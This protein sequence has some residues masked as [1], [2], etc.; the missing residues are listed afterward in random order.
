MS[1]TQ[2]SKSDLF[3]TFLKLGLTSFGGPIAHLGYFRE[4]F[5]SRLKWMD[6]KTYADLVALCQFLPGPTSSQVGLGV[7]LLKGGGWGAVLAWT[8]FTIPS[9]LALMIFGFGVLEYSDHIPIGILTGLKV[10]T[11]AVVTQAVVGMWRSLCPDIPRSILAL[12]GAIFLIFLPSPL[13]QI[14]V[15][16]AGGGIGY[17]FSKPAAVHTRPDYLKTS[18]SFGL[19]NILTGTFFVLLIGLPILVT[20]YDY[21]LLQIIESFYRAGSLVFGGG[22]VVLPL[23]ENSVVDQGWVNKESFMAGY[24]AAQAV[25]GPLFTFAAYLGTVLGSSYNGVTGAVICL[26]V[27]FL[28]SFLLVPAL[29]PYW[30]KVNPYQS[31]QKALMG[32]NAAVV[33]VIAAALIDPILI[34][35]PLEMPTITLAILALV[36]LMVAKF[37]P[38]LVVIG[39]ALAGW[40]L[41]NLF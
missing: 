32:V 38:W 20:F 7:G 33:G 37:P 29:L 10:V 2:P 34:S 24:G 36:A 31:V 18:I 15:L 17:L 40:G 28:P 22:H 23:L 1:D 6:E 39:T 19:A 35:V 16:I 41:E 8:G 12:I 14:L 27:I 30:A 25:P 4:A 11:L 21:E 9:A 5:V 26:L 3:L 13:H